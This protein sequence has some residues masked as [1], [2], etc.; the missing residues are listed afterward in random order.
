MKKTEANQEAL[1]ALDV[2]CK[3]LMESIVTP[4]RGKRES[5]V[6]VELNDSIGRLAEYDCSISLSNVSHNSH[7]GLHTLYD[8][9]RRSTS[10][11]LLAAINSDDDSVK[12]EDMNNGITLLLESFSVS[13]LNPSLPNFT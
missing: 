13:C 9:L 11:K 4:L 6:S 12:I 2:R 5:Q 3:R 8:E 7:S 10:G 1:Q